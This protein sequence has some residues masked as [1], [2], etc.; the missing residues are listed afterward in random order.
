[1]ENNRF[2]ID[3][4]TEKLLQEE[5]INQK[6]IKN[7]EKLFKKKERNLKRLQEEHDKLMSILRAEEDIKR[8]KKAKEREI[9]KQKHLCLLKIF[10]VSIEYFS[11]YNKFINFSKNTIDLNY[12]LTLDKWIIEREKLKNAFNERNQHIIE[13]YMCQDNKMSCSYNHPILSN[14]CLNDIKI[15]INFFGLFND[16]YD[17]DNID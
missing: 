15:L 8:I 10:T 11:K 5:L 12:I 3:E 14:Y 6:E 13:C 16:D 1:M 4:D 2:F 9:N 17:L 7:K